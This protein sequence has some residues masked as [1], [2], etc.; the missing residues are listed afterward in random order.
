MERS[1]GIT[2]ACDGTARV[3][4][5]GQDGEAARLAPAVLHVADDGVGIPVDDRDDI[6]ERGYSTARDGTGLGLR[7]AAQIA[8]AHGW[9]IRV[10]DS[11]DGGAR[12][13]VTGVDSPE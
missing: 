3:G 5:C 7:I 2:F 9:E 10:T 6:F 13:D 11:D 4:T 12:F 8:D 1:R